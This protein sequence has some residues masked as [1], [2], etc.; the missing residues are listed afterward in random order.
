[1]KKVD[2][3]INKIIPVKTYFN[4]EITKLN[5]Y[6]DNRGKSGVYRWT[7]LIN[8]KSYVGST[9]NLTKRLQA[10]YSPKQLIHQ[11][12]K[13]KSAISSAILKN[14]L[15]N[16]KLEI[17]E[18]CETSLLIKKEQMYL[19]L[20]NP[21]YNILKIAG[22]RLGHKT[23]EETKE[24]ISLALRGRKFK[25]KSNNI[26]N[27]TP[28]IETKLKLSLRCKGVIVRVFDFSNNLINEFS[29]ITATANYFGVSEKFINKELNRN[30]SY[31]GFIFKSETKDIRIWVHDI[32]HQLVGVFTN[33]KKTSQEFNIPVT[34][35][36]RYINSGKLYKNRLYFYNLNYKNNSFN[37]NKID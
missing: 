35:L 34:T 6:K 30:K 20:L 32:N 31:L 14:G 12:N 26:K 36:R 1:M 5:I 4:L 19:D 16:F 8:G 9:V 24:I 10:Y 33:I 25:L 7:N 29:T 37:I 3:K 17:L 23:S 28:T 13:G 27:K 22:S 15:L 21:E 11:L 18:Y 2:L